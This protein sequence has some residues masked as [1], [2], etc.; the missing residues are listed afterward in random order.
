ME[1][2]EIQKSKRVAEEYI[3]SSLPGFYI[4]PVP[5]DG[6]CI[7][8]SFVECLKSV[9]IKAT[10]QSVTK[11]LREELS[12]DKYQKASSDNVVVIDAFDEFLK[13]PLSNYEADTTDMYIEALSMAYKVNVTIVQSDAVECKTFA[14][15]G[16]NHY[17]QTFYLVRTLSPHFDPVIPLCL[18]NSDNNNNST[19]D[20]NDKILH[21][22]TGSTDNR[23]WN[24]NSTEISNNINSSDANNEFNI[25][26]EQPDVEDAYTSIVEDSGSESDD[27]IVFIK[28]IDGVNDETPN[29]SPKR[30]PDGLP[31]VED[32]QCDG[33]DF[34]S[35]IQTSINSL[36]ASDVVR[37][38]FDFNHPS[39][40]SLIQLLYVDSEKVA[41]TTPL[42]NVTENKI[43]TV[44]D[45]A[46]SEITNDGN[47]AYYKT[48]NI[49]SSIE[50]LLC[51]FRREHG[52]ERGKD[53]SYKRNRQ[54]QN[55]LLQNESLTTVHRCG[56]TKR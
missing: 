50:V 13:K 27:S 10:F 35:S 1:F 6:L 53:S 34:G 5:T 36:P 26:T 25:H 55:I 9:N 44:K 16:D 49:S 32:S 43:Y 54:Q 47:G 29:K 51:R 2:E 41:V 18:E 8:H 24:T 37:G 30:D 52:C 56:S 23:S 7:I 45:C 15:N 3:R 33:S 48:N 17:Q 21:D 39:A 46:I 31:G 42:K 28:V 22:T 38:D 4:S 40:E 20:L 19:N 12:K 14:V 11:S